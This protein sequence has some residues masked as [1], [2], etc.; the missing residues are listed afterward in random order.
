MYKTKDSKQDYERMEWFSI[1]HL[2]KYV[3]CNSETGLF[4]SP[5]LLDMVQLYL[6]VDQASACHG[7]CSLPV[8]TQPGP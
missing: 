1:M 5:I 4:G 6:C 3:P 8:C 7:Y 2:Y